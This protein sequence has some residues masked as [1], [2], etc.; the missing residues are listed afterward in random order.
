MRIAVIDSGVYEGHPHVGR[1]AASVH[2]AANGLGDDPVDRLGHGTA[3]A[4]AIREKAPQADLFSVKVF[5]RR[6]SAKIQAILRA[7]AWCRNQHM[8]L[9]NLSLGTGNPDHRALLADAVAGNAIV[10]SA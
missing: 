8:D 7:L 9:I 5:D 2:M 10:I 6:L 3:V 4:A 1:V